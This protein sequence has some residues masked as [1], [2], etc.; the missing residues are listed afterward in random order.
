[1]TWLSDEP[2]P[3]THRAWVSGKGGKPTDLVLRTLPLPEPEAG[4]V[5]VENQLIGLNPVD[6]KVLEERAPGEIPGCDGAGVVT[7]VGEGVPWHWIGT[8]VAYHTALARAGSFAELTSV[9]ARALLRIPPAL[10]TATAASMPCPALTAWQAISKIPAPGGESGAA[11]SLLISGAGGAVGLYALQLAR[12][13]NFAVSVLCHPRHHSRLRSLGAEQVFDKAAVDDNKEELQSTFHAI[14]DATGSDGAAKLAFS[15]KAN[16][17]LVCVLGRVAEWPAPAFTCAWS[18]HEVA[19]GG[20]HQYGDEADWAE[21]THAGERIL[22]ELAARRMVPETLHVKPFQALPE[23]LEALRL[24]NFSG[25]ALVAVKEA[26][27]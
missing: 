25:K 16:G 22:E 14:I 21:L 6:W 7:A 5:L 27:S 8:R 19:L 18:L 3:E 15:L 4:C 13:R 1:M 2:L 20:L 23:H 11:K 17:H 10:D 26:E 24:R 12:A 9:P